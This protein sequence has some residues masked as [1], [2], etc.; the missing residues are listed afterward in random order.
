MHRSCTG[1]TTGQTVGQTIGQALLLAVTV[2]LTS[3]AIA[4]R[5]A[6]LTIDLAQPKPKASPQ[7]YGLMTEEINYSYDG[8]LYGEL[9]RNRT[10]Q[11]RGKIPPSWFLYEEGTAQ[12]SMAID[13][14]TGSSAALPLSLHLTVKAASAHDQAGII[15]LGYWG[16]PVRPQTAYH[17]SF[18]ARA[19]DPSIGAVT[20]SLI[21]NETGKAISTTVPA[22][23]SEWQQHEF[24]LHSNAE[25]KSSQYH[26]VL[27][28]GKPGTVWFTLVSLFPPTYH[29]R[30]N[31]NRIDLMEKLAAMK[32]AFLRFPGGNYLEGDHINE[33]YEWKKTIGPLV[34]RP[35]HMS[36][37]GYRSTDGMGLL[38]F[39]EWCEDLN[40]QPLLA[41]YAG[42]SMK[43]EF[44]KPGP[45]LDPYV[46]DALDEIEYVT[47]DA[48]TKW[49]AERVKDGHP[50]P[51]KL[52]YVEIGN[53]D[54]FDQSGSYG[55]RYAQFY[56]AIKAKYPDLQLIATTPI[57]TMKPDVI[58]DHYYRGAHEFYDDVHHYDQ[59]DRNGPKIFVGEWATREGLPT[60]NFGAALGDAAWM[61]GMERNSDIVI[62][63]SYAPLLV[64]VNPGGMQWE[65]DLIGYDAIS[66]YGS[67]S[68]YAQVMFAS[69]IGDEILN[70]KLEGAP[71]KLFYSVTRKSSDGTVYLKLVNA[72]S[73]PQPVHIEF[74]GGK[75]A[76]SGKLTSLSAKTTAA[77]NSITQPTAIVP[78]E[79]GVH[80]LASH[81]VPGYTIQVLELKAQ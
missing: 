14:T 58:D 75:A 70:A 2:L 31:G 16:F 50:A 55:G 57:T 17:G 33:R 15:N 27:S 65:S 20:V 53:E 24:T 66:S 12:A 25:A 47:G 49:G 73:T 3:A 36:P 40:M 38:E 80:D 1:Q 61:T 52:S 28:V 72:S 7:L 43:Q 6:T 74:N 68:Y 4:Q 76:A 77:T 62:M 41:V 59:T 13:R 44:V 81:T 18:Y 21:E 78:V 23:T 30:N 60:P 35:T 56:K 10:F 26:L 46:E 54:W 39:L 9:V 42:Y 11:D 79:S 45:D 48:S 69:H 67:P 22:L 34:D 19:S 29:D 32:P 5:A 37:W 8:G 51:F 71:P 64:N 63:A